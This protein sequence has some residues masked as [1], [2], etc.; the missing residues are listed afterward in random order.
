[1]GLQ[2]K[3]VPSERKE[4]DRVVCDRCDQVI[5]KHDK[6]HWNDF[7]E[8]YTCYHE[9]F[10]D[11]FFEIKQTWGYS[12]GKDGEYHEAVLCEPCYDLVFKDV[13]IKVTNYF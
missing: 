5:K 11:N 1:M 10:F 4:L 6:G 7:G 8:P 2:Y 3:V 9:P 12:S 13:Q